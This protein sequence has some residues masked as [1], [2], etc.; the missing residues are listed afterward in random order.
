MLLLDARAARITWTVLVFAAAIGLVYVLRHLLLLFAFSLF[1][2][3]LIFPLVRLV[4]RWVPLA[5]GRTRA[6]TVVYLVLLVGLGAAGAG[7]VPRLTRELASLADRLPEMSRQIESG[8]IVSGALLRR[9]WETEQ[10]RELARV[11]QAH[12]GEIIGY[13]QRAF[14]ALL[15]WLS[16][17][18]VIVLIPIFAFF[19][20]KDA[21]RFAAGG[22]NLIES[23]PQRRLWSDIADDLHLLLGEYVRALIILSLITFVVWSLLF[24]LTGVPY[25]IL[26]A[27]IGGVLEFIPVVGP[28]A[29]GVIVVGVALFSGFAHPWLLLLFV[30]LWRLV[31][32]YAS[33]PLVMGRGIEIHPA[34]VMFGVI[35]GGEIGGPAGMFLSVPA[36]AGLRVVWRR[37]HAYRLAAAPGAGTGA[38][39]SSHPRREP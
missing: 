15:G 27:A 13:A 20:L 36:I 6:I 28:L 26:L 23:Q 16:G 25:A 21:E 35:A 38:T 22:A 24:F 18:W 30:L 37:L 12:A 4:E 7:I 29:A 9:G 1:F 10:I 3:Y 31:Q 8:E 32:D 34:L 17:A 2:A 39:R 11:V 14:A 19:I 33:S 5:H